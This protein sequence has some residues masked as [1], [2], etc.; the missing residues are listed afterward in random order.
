MPMN[1]HLGLGRDRV[2]AP[3]LRTSEQNNSP[4]ES[5]INQRIRY[6][7]HTFCRDAVDHG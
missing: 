4:P 5:E 3:R 7:K 2:G 6:D 1:A